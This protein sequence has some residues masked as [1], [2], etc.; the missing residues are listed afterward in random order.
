MEGLFIERIQ[1]SPHLPY[2]KRMAMYFNTLS[3][4]EDTVMTTFIMLTRL[5]PDALRSPK[6]LKEL[7]KKV[8]DSIRSQCPEVEWVHNFALLGP[9]DYLDVFR[10]RDMDTAFK[11]ATIVRTFGHAHTEIWGATEWAAFKDMVRRLPGK[12]EK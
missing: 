7:E 3:R 5:S 12:A 6:S 2:K 8:M 9:Y 4:R 11:V 10:A 1:G